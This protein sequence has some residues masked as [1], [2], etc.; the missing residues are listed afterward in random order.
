MLKENIKV[1]D[2]VYFNEKS[3]DTIFRGIVSII[4]ENSIEVEHV[5]RRI[6]KNDGFCPQFGAY[7]AT[8]EEIYLSE[9]EAWKSR[10]KK[11][12]LEI[13]VKMYD[14][15][16]RMWEL[17][18]AKLEDDWD[19]CIDGVWYGLN[20]DMD[21][22]DRVDLLLTIENNNLELQNIPLWNCCKDAQNSGFKKMVRTDADTVYLLEYEK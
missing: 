8:Y 3:Y 2:I 17:H 9:E 20:L 21:T 22:S 7:E 10:T 15:L 5:Y 11:K 6:S 13:P 19:I 4:K 16:G 14:K 1:G 12:L 18:R